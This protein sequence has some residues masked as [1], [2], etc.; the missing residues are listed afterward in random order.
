LWANRQV[1]A[2]TI[3]PK[4]FLLTKDT[5]RSG[6]STLLST[7]VRL[8]DLTTGTI[9]LDS[10]DLSLLQRSKI[11]QQITSI[12][13]DPLQIT[14]T[15]RFNADPFG[16][17]TD[18]QIISALTKVDLWSLLNERGGLD[19]E[20]LPDTLSKGQLQLLALAR[21]LLRKS[22]LVLM[23]EATSNI[24]SET[25][26]KINEILKEEFRDATILTVA[27]K[28]ETILSAQI[29]VLMEL[30]EIVEVGSPEGLMG[31]KGSKLRA[32]LEEEKEVGA[33]I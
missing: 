25:A 18:T 20:L 8:Q 24:D 26:W 2:L 13:Q 15:L 33:G 11:R 10:L 32:L 21:T 27:H 9:K 1:S 5:F 14:G 22:K 17:C 28:Q 31:S 23:D 16:L 30:G 19:A 6:K 29:V 7:V 3:I 4:E 12:P